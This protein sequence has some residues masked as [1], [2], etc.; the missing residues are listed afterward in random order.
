M[1]LTVLVWDRQRPPGGIPEL[2]QRLHR[3]RRWL[4][5][6]LLLAALRDP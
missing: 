3:R 5:P 4:G 1:A 6:P 2:P